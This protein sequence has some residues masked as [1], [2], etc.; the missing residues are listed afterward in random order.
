MK[1]YKVFSKVDFYHVPSQEYIEKCI[2]KRVR[3]RN[4]QDACDL[5]TRNMNYLRV[6]AA[7]LGLLIMGVEILGATIFLD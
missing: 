6:H 4:S 1:E 2:T 3:A 5:L 7:N